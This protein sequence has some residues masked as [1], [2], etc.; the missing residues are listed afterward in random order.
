MADR[1]PKQDDLP[2]SDRRR[3]LGRLAIGVGWSALGAW[4]V[5]GAAAA[6][7]YFFPRISYEPS[8]SF[9]IGR[10]DDY[11]VGS[12]DSRW[13]KERSLV[14]VRTA[15]GIYAMRAKCTHLGCNITWFNSE[16][17]FKCPCHGSYF[18]LEGDVIGGPAP[19]PLFRTA[20]RLDRRGRIIVDVAD[21]ENAPG[22]REKDDYN[23]KA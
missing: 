19:E 13:V 8:T 2:S 9:P 12:I 5:G 14:V 11:V 6:T 16:R 20:L 1:S 18:D 17:R 7:R 21:T 23:L 4:V 3:L 10:P 15:K 22:R